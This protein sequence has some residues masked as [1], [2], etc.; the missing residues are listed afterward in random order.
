MANGHAV[1][2]VH[3]TQDAIAAIQAERY[4]LVVTDLLMPGG[5]GQEVLAFARS[6]DV[7]PPVLVITGLMA[8]RVEEDALA[9]GARGVIHK[10]FSRTELTGAVC[11]RTTRA[12]ATGAEREARRAAWGQRPEPTG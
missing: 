5:G 8:R 2:C 6:A 7:P 12:E 3:N 9:M 4:D 10:P 11:S 1:K